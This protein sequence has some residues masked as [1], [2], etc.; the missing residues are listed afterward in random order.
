[1]KLVVYVSLYAASASFL[2]VAGCSP[3]GSPPRQVDRGPAGPIDLDPPSALSDADSP[4]SDRPVEPAT[5]A[6]TSSSPVQPSPP[7]PS[8]QA[9]DPASAFVLPPDLPDD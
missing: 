5:P 2:V 9:V 8:D 3:Q 6:V 1:M 4:W 7:S